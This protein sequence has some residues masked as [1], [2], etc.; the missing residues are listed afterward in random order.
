MERSLSAAAG[1]RGRAWPGASP[2][3]TL[4][5]LTEIEAESCRR[6]LAGRRYRLTGGP[7]RQPGSAVRHARIWRITVPDRCTGRDRRSS[8]WTTRTIA[9][10]SHG[11]MQGLRSLKSP[12]TSR[13]VRRERRSS[14]GPSGFRSPT[15]ASAGAGSLRATALVR[16]CST[17]RAP[18]EWLGEK[19]SACPWRRC[20]VL[21]WRR[22]L[23]YRTTVG[24]ESIC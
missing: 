23:F 22:Q 20:L 7:E 1:S 19:A 15:P 9:G 21:P 16:R 6:S 2:I 5:P 12:A 24:A 8:T 18:P 17:A 4:T 3:S 10:T 11:A 13:R 14:H